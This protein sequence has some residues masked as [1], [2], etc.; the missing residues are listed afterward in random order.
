MLATILMDN[1]ACFALV[2]PRTKWQPFWQTTIPIA[3]PWMKIREFRFQFHWNMFPGVQL[4]ISQHWFSQWL[5]A[6]LATSHCLGQW[7]PSISTHICFTRGRYVNGASAVYTR[8]TIVNS[9]DQHQIKT[10]AA[11]G[12]WRCFDCGVRSIKQLW[13]DCFALL[14]ARHLADVSCYIGPSMPSGI[15][16]EIHTEIVQKRKKKPSHNKGT[17]RQPHVYS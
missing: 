1:V 5:D 2:H 4:T 9:V 8:D 10:H 15:C 6:E 16:M 14:F 3:F 7:W 11:T 13:L 17:P 12:S